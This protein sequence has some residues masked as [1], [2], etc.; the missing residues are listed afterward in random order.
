MAA[1]D[2]NGCAPTWFKDLTLCLAH[3][4]LLSL[5]IHDIVG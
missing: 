3:P 2:Y 1:A 5:P 4:H